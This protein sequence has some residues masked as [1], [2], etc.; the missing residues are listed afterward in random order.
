MLFSELYSAYYNAVAKI[1]ACAVRGDLN[2]SEMQKIVSENA[3]SES[4]L[5]VIPA[6]KN[7]EWQLVTGD[8]R[9]P[10]EHMPTM[11]LTLL[12]KRWLKAVSLDKRI[13]LFDADFGFLEGVEPLFKPDDIYA[14]DAYSDG[15]DYESETYIQNFKLILD[16][17]KNRYPIKMEVKN[18]HGTAVQMNVVPEYIEYSEK[19]DKFRLITSGCSYGGTVNIGRVV[20]AKRYY[21][22]SVNIRGSEPRK[23]R[24]LVLEVYNKRNALERVMLHFAHFEKKAEKVDDGKYRVEIFYDVSDETEMVIRVLS[25]GPM[26][27]ALAP[28]GFVKLIRERLE[29]QKMCG[30]W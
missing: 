26:I 28:M 7:G 27:K 21:G 13:K 23:P 18:R 22:S 14:F 5:T 29:K 8:L 6:L 3:F 10:I 25:F 19:D 16:A 2:E 12:Q 20:S 4:V 1:L 9:T 30:L 24:R 11:P 15:D 17:V